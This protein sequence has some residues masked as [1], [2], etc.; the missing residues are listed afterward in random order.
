MLRHD[1]MDSTT[2]FS[3]LRF[4]GERVLWLEAPARNETTEEWLE[5]LYEL[6]SSLGNVRLWFGGGGEGDG[7]SDRSGTGSSNSN[8]QWVAVLPPQFE[9]LLEKVD[10]IHVDIINSHI[11]KATPV[12]RA[13]GVG[14]ERARFE[15]KM[16]GGVLTLERTREWLCS[17]M[18]SEWARGKTMQVEER[19]RGV[20]STTTTTTIPLLQALQASREE[21]LVLLLRKGITSLLTTN[22]TPADMVSFDAEVTAEPLL[23]EAV[24]PETLSFDAQRI[25]GARQ[26][27]LVVARAATLAAYIVQTLGGKGV[28]MEERKSIVDQLMVLLPDEDVRSDDIRLQVAHITKSLAAATT[29]TT[30]TTSF[31]SSSGVVV[32]VPEQEM[33]VLDGRVENMLSTGRCPVLHLFYQRAVEVIQTLLEHNGAMNEEEVETTCRKMGL[34]GLGTYLAKLSDVLLVVCRHHEVVFKPY[35]SRLVYE[36]LTPQ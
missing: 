11:R 15:E 2:I 18:W 27:A 24:L 16:K 31:S 34:G 30:T 36:G 14:Y 9:F 32:V 29:T 21:A 4:A 25:D 19:G 22:L 10:Q 7:D 28:G 23:V 26:G 12:I 13:Q 6:E 20:M 8:S 17:I 5:K 35:Y 3:I 1:V 33:R